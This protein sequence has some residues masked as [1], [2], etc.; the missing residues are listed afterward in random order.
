[1]KRTLTRLQKL[2]IIEYLLSKDIKNL[3]KYELEKLLEF[4]QLKTIEALD[5]FNI[6]I[7]K[8]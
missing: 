7:K 4:S 2:E 6:C 5:Y 3:S 1:M 8:P